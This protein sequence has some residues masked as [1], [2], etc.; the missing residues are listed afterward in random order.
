[1]GLSTRLLFLRSSLFK[2]FGYTIFFQLLNLIVPIVA[3]P[4]IIKS[5]GISKF[6]IVSY[7]L[8]IV[9][10][11]GSV[12][13]YGFNISAT[14]EI[15]EIKEDKKRVSGIFFSVI[16]AKI[17]L[18]SVVGVIYIIA[19]FLIEK[20]R[21]EYLL[22]LFSFLIVIGNIFIPAWYFQA[23]ERFKLLAIFNGISKI[24]YF[25][26]ILLIIKT[27]KDAYLV[28]LLLGISNFILAIV[29]FGFVLI[30][31][32]LSFKYKLSVSEVSA[33]IK[34]GWHFFLSSFATNIYS[35]SST[36]ILGSISNNASIVGYYSV[37]EKIYFLLKQPLLI[38]VQ[39]IYPRMFDYT[40]TRFKEL[41][42][43]IVKSVTIFALLYFTICSSFFILARHIIL[44]YTK[45]IINDQILFVFRMFCF[46]P[47]AVLLINA[48]PYLLLIFLHKEKVNSRILIKSIFI[49]LLC[50]FILSFYFS[51]YGTALALIS[52]EIFVG[53]SFM[54]ALK[55]A[56]KEI[57][58]K[59]DSILY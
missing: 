54:L 23:Y 46:L 27:P 35:Y 25:L 2:N 12:I 11:L 4:R 21:D 52:T 1:M 7:S 33:Q 50:S 8:S 3:I 43:F 14:R 39:V 19:I 24:F 10:L 53:V 20:L 13:E 32:K 51:M 15:A 28:N 31:D 47:L 58:R 18:A 48:G 44:F 5:I 45:G 49:N 36:I 9:L 57:G 38:F 26:L 16:F 37:A 30:K 17:A 22:H 55:K 56:E 40:Q 41:K 29:C 59:L 6:G 42:N 34:K